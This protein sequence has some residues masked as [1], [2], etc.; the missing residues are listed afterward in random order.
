MSL[1]EFCTCPKCHAVWTHLETGDIDSDWRWAEEHYL[2][3]TKCP[4]CGLTTAGLTSQERR[5]WKHVWR[6]EYRRV[7]EDGNIEVDR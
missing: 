5:Q 6:D 3:A 2:P 1:R 7:V 4:E